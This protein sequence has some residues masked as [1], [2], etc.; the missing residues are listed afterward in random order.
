[1]NDQRIKLRR[2]KPA[3]YRTVETVT[4]EAFWNLHAPGCDEHYLA[5]IL[6]ASDAFIPALDYVAEVDGTIAGNIMY[7]ASRIALDA[8]SELPV[9][10]FGPVSVLPEY[11]RQGIGRR[12][13]KHTRALAR[14]M[15]YSAIFI[16]GDPAYYGPL[17]FE[18]AELWNVGTADNL[19]HSA[20][21]AFELTPGA[22][23]LAAGRFLEDPV[24]HL[25]EAA[26]AAFDQTFPVK[27]KLSGTPSQQRFMEVLA[28]HRPRG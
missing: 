13:I 4:R 16:Y 27:E 24:Y 22:L 6:R 11:Q 20:L 2:E 18:P 17:G 8:G 26:A 5:H 3:D 10:T 14:Q 1:M 12:M 28:M 7:A 25:D 21:Q 19:Y 23:D 9:I 15:G